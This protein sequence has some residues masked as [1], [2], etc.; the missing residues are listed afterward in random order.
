MNSKRNNLWALNEKVVEDKTN[1]F[2]NTKRNDLWTQ[3][4]TVYEHKTK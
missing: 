4:E 3:Y 2:T 1:Q